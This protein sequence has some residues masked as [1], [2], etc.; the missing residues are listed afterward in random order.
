[1]S[2]I[3]EDISFEYEN[4]VLHEGLG[5]VDRWIDCALSTLSTICFLYIHNGFGE[6]SEDGVPN[7]PTCIVAD[8]K[9]N[10]VIFMV[11]SS[12]LTD[13]NGSHIGDNR[14]GVTG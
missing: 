11:G 9:T 2:T 12:I 5:T 14:I 6:L 3:V 4:T 10:V 13:T 1:M 8:F 7:L